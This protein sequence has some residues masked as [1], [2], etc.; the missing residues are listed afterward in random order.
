MVPLFLLAWAFAAGAGEMDLSGLVANYYGNPNFWF[1]A[2]QFAVDSAE[3]DKDLGKLSWPENKWDKQDSIF[4]RQAGWSIAMKGFL[5]VKEGGAYKF[6]WKGH[7]ASLRFGSEW[8]D[9]DGAKPIEL[10]AGKNAFI[11]FIKSDYDI[12]KRSWSG[13]MKLRGALRWQAPESPTFESI[14]ASCL[15]HKAEDAVE[16]EAFKADIPLGE[17]STPFIGARDYTVQIPADGFYRFFMHFKAC[18]PWLPYYAAVYL[19]GEPLVHYKARGNGRELGFLNTLEESRLMKKGEHKVRV[20]S[21]T[22]HL[23]HTDMDGFLSNA[24][25]GFFKLSDKNPELCLG[26]V[27]KGRRDM[28]FKKGEPLE[29]ELARPPI[30]EETPY[31]LEVRGQRDEQSQVWTKEIKLK[32][33]GAIASGVIEYPCDKEGAFEYS[34][35]DSSGKRIAG[36]WSFVVV[37]TTPIPAPKL[38]G[39]IPAENK[40]LVDSV[41]CTLGADPEHHFRDNGTSKVLS[42]KDGNYRVTGDSRRRTVSY[43]KTKEGPWVQVGDKEQHEISATA[44]DWFAYTMKVRNPGKPHILTAYVPTDVRRLVPLMAYDQVTGQSSAAVLD[45]GDSKGGEAFTKLS[46]VL[47][48]NG[49]AIDVSTFCDNDAR[50]PEQ[51][52]Q[53]AI[54]KLELYE[55]PDGLP[56]LPQGPDGWSK[57]KEFGCAGEQIDI[58]IEQRTMPKFWSGDPKAIPGVVPGWQWGR[59]GYLDWKAL[60]EA[61]NRFG[62]YAMHCGINTVIWPV[63]TYGIS[64]LHTDKIPNDDEAY[65]TGYAY[66]PVDRWRRDELKMILMICGK[67]NVRFVADMMVQRI[68]YE[69]ILAANGGDKAKCPEEGLFLSDVNGNVITYPARIMNPSNPIC[70]R[71]LI[72][73]MEE[74]GT[75]YGDC[76]GFGGVN[77]RQWDEWHSNNSG[78]F[79]NANIGY[80]D[81]T[82]GLFERE[83]GVKLSIASDDPDRFKKRREALIDKANRD[84]WFKWRADKVVSLREELLAALRKHAPQAILYGG[85]KPELGLGQGLDHER[86]LGRRDLGFG[87][88]VE[89]GGPGIEVNELDPVTYA[90]FDIREPAGIRRSLQNLFNNGFAYPWGLCSGQF[91]SIRSNPYQLEPMAKALSAKP[92]DTIVYGSCWLLPPLD[93]GLRNWVRAWRSI[94]DIKFKS[95]DLKGQ[96]VSLRYA[97]KDGKLILY[98][99]NATAIEQELTLRIDASGPSLTNL[100]DGSRL[101]AENAGMLSSIVGMASSLDGE[102]KL[103][104][105]PFGLSVCRT[106]GAGTLVRASSLPFGTKPKTVDIVN[107]SS[108]SASWQDAASPWRRSLRIEN[109][110]GL[111]RDSTIITVK[112]SELMRGIEGRDIN[113]DS[114]LVYVDGHKTLIQVDRKS[115]DSFL[116]A[117]QAPLK[118][119]DEISLPASFK[120]GELSKQATFLWGGPKKASMTEP[121]LLKC[122]SNDKVDNARPYFLF[123]G[124]QTLQ[125]GVLGKAAKAGNDWPNWKEGTAS[126]LKSNGHDFLT[127]YFCNTNVPPKWPSDLESLEFAAKGP[128]TAVIE[129][130]YAPKDLESYLNK[131]WAS[132]GWIPAAHSSYRYRL[133]AFSGALGVSH[134][135]DYKETKLPI[136]KL[137]WH[138]IFINPGA[139]GVN[140]DCDFYYAKGSEIISGSFKDLMAGKLADGKLVDHIASPD[141]YDGMIAFFNRRDGIGMA[142]LGEPVK[143]SLRLSVHKGTAVDKAGGYMVLGVVYNVSELPPSH[144]ERDYSFVPLKSADKE[145]LA[146]LRLRFLNPLK[147]KC[148]D[149]VEHIE[150][151]GAGK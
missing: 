13:D 47:W 143:N 20:Y 56:A 95:F 111:A 10:K 133:D 92:L 16:R 41:D 21:Y 141:S 11:L 135:L 43:H 67:Y 76:Q 139:S 132:D 29:L 49:D 117:S 134:I 144:L 150:N 32:A 19:D 26:V 57:D 70:R 145:S 68:D 126:C 122:E 90:N 96:D 63:A 72:E 17:A 1:Y 86:L 85:A 12:E 140:Q 77:I 66:R 78:W 124:N 110:L 149:K 37:D 101:K 151:K 102:F 60:S 24:R 73:M 125:F 5:D 114:L 52:R 146:Q 4:N 115:G 54:A 23:A 46:C 7:A 130:K 69:R 62:Q 58:G 34:L 64:Y 61:W 14:P 83:T 55:Y 100:A 15:G 6:S 35:M 33:A 94:S 91:S 109:P 142:L 89:C 148:E 51:L 129:S 128:L 80:E 131:D 118:G 93:D 2:G 71:Y 36:P 50:W 44:S 84:A 87:S 127:F 104:L 121:G 120:S 147:V 108:E 42:G 119:D 107:V 38:K 88:K 136:L 106:D 99:V 97:L 74:I 81:F 48:P 45:S 22:A 18:Q 116:P 3:I 53:G 123:A 30:S 79:P 138:Y 27:E 8:V 137:L 113:P 28:V 59:G 31:R 75:L 103:K 98:A 82:V 112:A 40:V 9:L 105:A 25:M 39:S 65:G